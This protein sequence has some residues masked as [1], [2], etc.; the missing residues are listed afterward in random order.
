MHLVLTYFD[1][2]KGP[3]IFLSFP[4]VKLEEDIINKL[5]KFFDLDINETFFE[6]VLINKNKKIINLYIEIPSE[7]ARG[8]KEMVM[9][10]LIMK[11]SYPSELLYAFIV[12]TS[13][14]I[15]KTDN[16]FKAFYKDDDNYNNNIEVF[17]AHE[18]IRLILFDSLTALIL[19]MESKKKKKMS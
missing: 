9:L 11:K 16:V 17:L 2:L 8:K 7:W 1:R 10:S 18:Q 12:E 14:K 6:I 5:I 13:H 3:S 4:E 15:L 19:R